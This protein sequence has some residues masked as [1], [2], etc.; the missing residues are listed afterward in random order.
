MR[1]SQSVYFGIAAMSAGLIGALAGCA[2]D[3]TGPTTEIEANAGFTV[4]RQ[5][6]L[7]CTPQP[8]AV[9]R[10]VIGPNGGE[11]KVGKNEFKVPKGS[12]LLPTMITMEL[13]SDTVSSVRFSPEGLVF[14]PMALP[15]VKFDYKHCQVPKGLKPKV[16]YTTESLRIIETLPSA[17]DST[18]STVGARPRHFSRYAITY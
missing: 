17:S 5:G 18:T 6:L 15:T 11:I 1:R 2:N 8:Y 10:A 9:G 7:R 3:A 16:A 12:L 4:V 14:N 13:P